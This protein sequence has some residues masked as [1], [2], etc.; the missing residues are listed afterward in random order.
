MKL[1]HIAIKNVDGVIDRLLSMGY[2]E[3]GEHG[4]GDIPWV[5]IIV[6]VSVVFGK[7]ILHSMY[8]EN[9]GHPVID[10]DDIPERKDL[11]EWVRMYKEGFKM[12]LL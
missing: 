9:Y 12:G 1:E 5:F 11:E 10:I 6:G 4:V 7:I 3:Y 2:I 8:I